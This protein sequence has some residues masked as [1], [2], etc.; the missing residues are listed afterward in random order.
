M[1]TA[2]KLSCSHMILHPGSGRYK[3]RKDFN[4]AKKLLAISV[5]ELAKNA[6]KKGVV[7]SLENMLAYSDVQRVGT[8][9]TELRQI[10]ESLPVENVGICLDTGHAHFNRL[11]VSKETRD[12]DSLLIDLHV[13][14]NDSSG[15]QHR[16]PGGGTIKWLSFMKALREIKYSGIFTLEIYGGEN[17]IRKLEDSYKEALKLLDY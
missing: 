5:Q 9:V 1:K 3:E 17:A 14:D 4:K 8:N 15:D 16:V 2:E 13:N 10:I 11:D 7:L 6:Y 12:A